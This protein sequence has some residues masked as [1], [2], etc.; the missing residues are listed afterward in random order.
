MHLITLLADVLQHGQYLLFV[1]GVVLTSLWV[2]VTG[3]AHAHYVK[4]FPRVRKIGF[5]LGCLIIPPRPYRF[6]P[7]STSP[8]N[9]TWDEERETFAPKY[10]LEPR[11][12]PYYLPSEG[13]TSPEV[14][15]R[16]TITLSH[17][18]GGD[19][20]ET[21]EFVQNVTLTDVLDLTE[22]LQTWG[23]PH[24][25]YHDQSNDIAIVPPYVSYSSLQVLGVVG[26]NRESHVLPLFGE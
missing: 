10:S 7:P 8:K 17:Y 6:T 16:V 1:G 13:K 20:I 3:A 23:G 24:L 12:G 26:P 25:Y 2:L 18:P 9:E 22:F 5:R 4:D 21:S 14:L 11:A 19:R 15:A